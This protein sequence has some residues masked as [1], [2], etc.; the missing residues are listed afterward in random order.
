MKKLLAILMILCCCLVSLAA[1]EDAIPTPYAPVLEQVRKALAGD[2]DILMD[3]DFNSALYYLPLYDGTGI[4]WALMD[5][6]GD[7]S[8]ELLLGE[9]GNSEWIDGSILDIWTIRDGQAI[10]LG[11]GWERNRMYLTDEGDGTYG[12]YHEGSNSAFE[13]VCSHGL[14]RDGQL[15]DVTQIDIVSDMEAE[16]TTY[17]LNESIV[18]DEAI[19]GELIESWFALTMTMEFTPL[20]L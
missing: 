14:I 5:L 4:G 17:Y 1:A 16:D 13:S 6:D 15:V 18:I 10:L 11:R 7:G 19:A 8:D 9:V 12:L 3:D 20:M 2:E